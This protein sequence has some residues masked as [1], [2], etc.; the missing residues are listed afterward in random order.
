MHLIAIDTSKPLLC[1][2]RAVGKP[3][4]LDMCTLYM[5][6]QCASFSVKKVHTLPRQK[7]RNFQSDKIA[8]K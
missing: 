6:G 2:F 1:Q 3:L 8:K 7:L 4:P 5:N